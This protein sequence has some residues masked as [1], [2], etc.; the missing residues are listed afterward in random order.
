[1]LFRSEFNARFGDPETQA[2]LPRLKTPLAKLLF[3]AATGSLKDFPTL[4]WSHESSVTVVLAAKNYPESPVI[5]DEIN[6]PLK[7][8]NAEIFQAGTTDKD[9]TLRSNGGR[10]LS[11][12]GM[13]T[14]LDEARNRAYATLSQIGLPGSFYRNDIALKASQLEKR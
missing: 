1:M 8:T 9:G 14:S 3:A 7:I 2:L 13:G 6:L 12:T 4:E 5:G 11:V 10:V